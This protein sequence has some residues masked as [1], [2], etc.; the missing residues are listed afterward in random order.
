MNY[1]KSKIVIKP[2]GKGLYNSTW[3]YVPSKIA[4]DSSFPFKEGEEVLIEIK[5]DSLIIT[6]S[7]KKTRLM[8]KLG[9]PEIRLSKLLEVKAE[10][11]GDHKYLYYKDKSYTFDDINK[12]SNKFAWGILEIIQNLSLKKPK[13]AIMIR[14]CP[15]FLFA[16][17]GCIKA[18]CILVP[19]NP[20]FPEDYIKHILVD[21][22]SE[23]L[24][25]DYQLYSL[26]QKIKGYLP[27]IKKVYIH[28]APDSFHFGENVQNFNSIFTSNIENLSITIHNND[29]TQILYTEGITGK[30]KGVLYRNLV[31]SSIGISIELNKIGLTQN[32]KI[33]CVMPLFHGATQFYVIIP[34]LIHNGTVILAEKFDP[35]DFW[36]DV[37]K[38]KPDC[39]AYFGGYLIQ[40]L[41]NTPKRYDHQHS[42][43]WAYGFG[44][45][46]E[47][48]KPFETRFGI[49]LH[50]CWSH[51]EGIGITINSV[52]TKGGKMGS[53]GKSLSDIDLKIVDSEGKT[54]GTGPDNI[55]EIVV[56]SKYNYS[57][58]YYKE[59]EKTDV[60]IGENGWV[61]TGDYG[62]ID[63]DGYVYF[64]GKKNE[65]IIKANEMIFL[66][67]IEKTANSHPS[68]RISACIPVKNK[69]TNTTEMVL[70]AVKAKNSSITPQKLKNYLYHNLAFYQ[71]PRYIEFKDRL[72]IGPSTEYF[73]SKL[74][75]EWNSKILKKERKNE[76]LKV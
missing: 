48:W 13:I 26:Y 25:I 8:K 40:L 74:L 70:F 57:F 10:T 50:E 22:D 75:E 2:S 16:W 35:V 27:K 41:S 71:V 38:Y 68:I 72:P 52:G 7:N 39:F 58:E 44:A 18:G 12:S 23:I 17:F 67:E 56:R 63:D 53:V 60:R 15:N 36:K 24:L 65:I 5:N 42:L 43:R 4:K 64:M 47:I 45:G 54:L 19:I 11:F 69:S 46:V 55:G 73:K 30:P 66:K 29:P 21:S 34:S 28:N 32:T 20:D 6:K 1:G 62:Y 37:K 61:F 51:M 76:A 33:Y 3:I 59:P 31:S 14:N 9:V 49:T